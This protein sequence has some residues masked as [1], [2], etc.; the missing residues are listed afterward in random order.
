MESVGYLPLA[1]RGGVCRPSDGGRNSGSG[2]T[3]VHAC[4]DL[5]LKA[6]AGCSFAC[7]ASCSSSWSCCLF[8]ASLAGVLESQVL[9]DCAAV[10]A[11]R[12]GRWRGLDLSL[13]NQSKATAPPLLDAATTSQ[14]PSP[15]APAGACVLVC[16]GVAV[17]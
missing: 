2:S 15:P 17:V 7:S 9:F 1:Q 8:T 13:T 14:A 5:D 16:V 10:E 4:L 11:D 12:G 6:M 3:C